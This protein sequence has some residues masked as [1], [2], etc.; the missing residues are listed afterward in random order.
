MKKLL[1]LAMF[2]VAGFMS[3][4]TIETKITNENT[5]KVETTLEMIDYILPPAKI[6]NG[7]AIMDT[8]DGS[9]IVYGTYYTGDNGVSI[10]VVGSNATNASM[11]LPKC[12]GAGNYQA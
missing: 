1:L 3:A 12:S 6:E 9:C 7:L 5:K 10:F 8:A 11:G 4:S 2:S